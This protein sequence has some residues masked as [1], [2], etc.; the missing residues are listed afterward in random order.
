MSAPQPLYGD[1]LAY[2]HDVGFSGFANAAAPGVLKMLAGAG[3]QDGVV[4][5]LG[6]GTGH[7]ARHLTDAGYQVI[8]IDASAAAVAIARERAP[9]AVFHVGSLWDASIPRCRAVTALGEAVCYRAAGGR[10]QHLRTLFRRIFKAL[11]PGGLLIFDV[12]EVGL[13]RHRPP[14][15]F[16]GDDWACLVRFDYDERAHRLTRQITTFRRL[17]DLYRRSH[18]RHVVQLYNAA[19]VTRWPREAGF[20]VRTVRR[21]GSYPLPPKRVG[22]V[23]R[24][25]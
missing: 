6:C 3:I 20:R 22:F 9:A 17:G 8:G 24:K 14:A 11:E 12:A 1:D 23:A 10:R 25:P 4:V 18:E 13:A 7:W 2:V 19:E 5:D 15:G 16:E 21:F